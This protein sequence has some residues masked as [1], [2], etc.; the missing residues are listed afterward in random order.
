MLDKVKGRVLLQDQMGI[1]FI[2]VLVTAI[3]LGVGMLGIISLQTT[4]LQYNQQGY[5]YSQANFFG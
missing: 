3:I 5:L 2:E 1:S 4:G